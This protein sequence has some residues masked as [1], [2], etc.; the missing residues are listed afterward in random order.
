MSATKKAA[1]AGVSVAVTLQDDGSELVSVILTDTD[2]LPIT[3][4]QLNGVFPA[5]LLATAIALVFADATPGP[6]AFLF[7][8]LAAP[9]VSTAVAGAFDIGSVTAVQP[10][11]AGSGQ[12]VDST[13]TISGFAS[14]AVS[15][16][17]GTWTIVSD[18]NAPGGFSTVV[19]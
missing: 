8:P 11:V 4:A 19:T 17:A 6:S 18:P 14:G 5:A 7:T 13:L 9:A 10:V 1:A 16:D 3:P 2:G 12:G 15:E